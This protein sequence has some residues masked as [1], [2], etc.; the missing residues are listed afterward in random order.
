MC[1]IRLTRANLLTFHTI[2][3]ISHHNNKIQEVFT[4]LHFIVISMYMNKRKL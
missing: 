4:F 2:L 3:Y 1:A